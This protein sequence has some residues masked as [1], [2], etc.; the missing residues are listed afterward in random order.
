MKATKRIA[1][2]LLAI[3]IMAL[4][5]SPALAT[6]AYTTLSITQASEKNKVTLTEALE[7]SE[8]GTAFPNVTYTFTVNGGIKGYSEGGVNFYADSD[9]N[10]NASINPHGTVLGTVSFS[11]SDGTGADTVTKTVDF[12]LKGLTFT[13]PGIF[14]WEI[15]KTSSGAGA[16]KATNNQGK[17]YLVARVNDVSG[18]LTPIFSINTD[19]TSSSKRERIDDEYPVSNHS[20]TIAKTVDGNQG[21]KDEYFEFKVELSGLD[22]IAGSTLSVGGTATGT[23]SNTLYGEPGNYANPTQIP[24]DSQGKATATF[25]MKHGQ[26]VIINGLLED[27]KYKVTETAKDGY[28]TKHRID[29]TTSDGTTSTTT[30]GNDVSSNETGDQTMIGAATVRYNNNKATDVPTGIDLQTIAPL[31]GILLAGALLVVMKLGKRKGDNA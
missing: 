6:S 1:G 21:S 11:P 12:D 18:T 19:L 26:N 13:E 5:V 14:Y 7:V 20:L 8:Q 27:S 31:F 3:L 30:Q 16:A 24:V 2:A 29:I 10:A 25:W 17:L 23:P 28:T 9:L 4:S 15:D 22:A